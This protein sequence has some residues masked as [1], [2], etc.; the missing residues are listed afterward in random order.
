[1]RLKV[2]LLF[3]VYVVKHN[4]RLRK[5]YLQKSTQNIVQG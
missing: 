2:F 1:M 5:Q 3:I 4:Q